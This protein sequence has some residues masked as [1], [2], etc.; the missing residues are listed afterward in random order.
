MGSDDI[1]GILSKYAAADLS[2]GR[3]LA[4]R[5]KSTERH[6]SLHDSTAARIDDGA[7]ARLLLRRAHARMSVGRRR[8]RIFNDIYR[9]VISTVSRDARRDA[10][11]LYRRGG[12]AVNADASF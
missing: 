9:R 3:V 5:W 8:C 11:W 1:D 7:A 4:A 10:I 6:A 12:D 2:V